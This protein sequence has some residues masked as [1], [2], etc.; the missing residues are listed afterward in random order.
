MRRTYFL[1]TDTLCIDLAEHTS[2]EFEVINDN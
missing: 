1:N 2:T